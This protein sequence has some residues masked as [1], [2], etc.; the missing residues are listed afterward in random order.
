MEAGRGPGPLAFGDV[1]SYG[2][3]TSCS[4]TEVGAISNLGQCQVMLKYMPS[5]LGR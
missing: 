3:Y 4:R 5:F 2:F 1:V